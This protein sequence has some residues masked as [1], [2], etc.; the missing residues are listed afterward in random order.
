LDADVL[1]A[2]GLAVE[3]VERLTGSTPD[4]TAMGPQERLARLHPRGAAWVSVGAV[5]VGSLGPLH[6]DVVDALD[7]GGPALVVELDL[8]AIESL[9]PAVPKYKP[10]PRLPATSRDVSLVVSEDIAAAEIERELRAA[11]GSLCESVELFDVFSGGDIPA[12]RRSLAYRLVYRDP[13]ATID[14]THA[15]TLTDEEV[16]REHERVRGAAKRLGELRS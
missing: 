8:V 13:R 1:D 16:D 4:V 10:I 12:G 9:G 15:R 3:L 6:P 14:P 2:K 7:L 5:R 11:A